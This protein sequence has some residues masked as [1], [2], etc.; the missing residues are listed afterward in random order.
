[1]PRK[2]RYQ[3]IHRAQIKKL[4]RVKS[5]G[6]FQK[7]ELQIITTKST[8]M[9]ARQL[10]ATRKSIS[11]RLKL[12][13]KFFFYVFPDLPFTTKSTGMRMGG[14]KGELKDWR[15]KFRSGTALIKF[16]QSNLKTKSILKA[17]HFNK[18]NFTVLIR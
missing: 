15:C 1:M 6:V 4:N 11:R 2:R 8:V 16:K 13:S 10:E 3:K 14:G 17:L 18:F 12:I 7:Q 9:T 5:V